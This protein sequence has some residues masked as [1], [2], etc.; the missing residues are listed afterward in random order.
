MWGIA[1][2]KDW[3]SKRWGNPLTDIH[4]AELE[5]AR[6]IERRTLM[7]HQLRQ[8]PDLIEAQFEII[9]K[10]KEKLK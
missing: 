2:F 8:M 3:T 1:R 7:K 9:N 5:I 10:A 6:L 4:D